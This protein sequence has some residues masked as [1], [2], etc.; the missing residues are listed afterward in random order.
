M[1]PGTLPPDIYALARI[2]QFLKPQRIITH[3]H[4]Y[5]QITF[6]HHSLQIQTNAIPK[7]VWDVLWVGA[8]GFCSSFGFSLPLAFGGRRGSRGSW[9]NPYP[10]LIRVCSFLANFG[11]AWLC[12]Q[13][14]HIAF[15]HFHKPRWRF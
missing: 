6:H 8:I 7:M 13:C 2:S 4:L 12:R 3:R 15:C 11:V 14:C 10:R 1:V 9:S 5:F